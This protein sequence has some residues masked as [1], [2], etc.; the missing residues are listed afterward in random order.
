VH[1]KLA[2]D[3]Q[4]RHPMGAALQHAPSL[5]DRVRPR[6][7]PPPTLKALSSAPLFAICFSA[8]PCDTCGLWVIESLPSVRRRHRIRR[9]HRFL[10]TSF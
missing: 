3:R 10:C 7:P 1:A 4:N 8:L 2:Q 6:R 9:M 5:T